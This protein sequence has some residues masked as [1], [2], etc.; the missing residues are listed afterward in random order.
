MAPTRAKRSTTTKAEKTVMMGLD[1]PPALRHRRASIAQ[2]PPGAAPR[3][4][5]ARVAQLVEHVTE[6]HGVGGSIP[7]PG[8]TFFL[9]EI[10]CLAGKF[11]RKTPDNV[12]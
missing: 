8:T 4:T 10:N 2:A 12:I 9:I 5:Q 1:K 6:N 3:R 11:S 7:S